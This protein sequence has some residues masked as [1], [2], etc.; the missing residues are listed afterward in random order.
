M[1]AASLSGLCSTR[2]PWKQHQ[3]QYQLPTPCS[4]NSI[5]NIKHTSFPSTYFTTKESK[6][7]YNFQH[8][9]NQSVQML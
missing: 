8:I 7:G 4:S 3:R 9:E 6:D 2:K 5:G 1:I